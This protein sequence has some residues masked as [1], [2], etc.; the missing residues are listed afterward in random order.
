M[1]EPVSTSTSTSKYKKLSNFDEF[2]GVAWDVRHFRHSGIGAVV[3]ILRD[4]YCLG[5]GLRS[6]I[7]YLLSKCLQT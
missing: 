2:F 3:R 4:S 5:G 6:P 1:P 7:A